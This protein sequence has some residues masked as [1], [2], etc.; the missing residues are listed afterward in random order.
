[1]AF[2]IKQ[3]DTG[4]VLRATL[5]DSDGN[6][7][8][9]TG[10]SVQFHMEDLNGNLKVDAACVIVDG[11]SGIVDYEWVAADTEDSGTFYVEWEVTYADGTIETFPNRG[12]RSVVITKELN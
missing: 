8:N 2:Y 4:P 6:A 7:V 3:N 9:I 12:H 11:T 5:T 10:A 1:M